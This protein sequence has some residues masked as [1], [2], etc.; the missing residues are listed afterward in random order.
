MS[1]LQ[2]APRMEVSADFDQVA[3]VTYILVEQD[4]YSRYLIVNVLSSL[5]ACSV[6]PCFDIIFSEFGAPAQLKTDSGP[7]FNSSEFAQTVF[8]GRDIRTK[9]S[10]L[11][12]L[13]KIDSDLHA[14]DT[15][16]KEIMK[17]YADQKIYMKL[18]NL[19][20]RDD[21]LVIY[22]DVSKSKLPYQQEPLTVVAK[23]G[24]MIT[25]KRGEQ[26]LSRNSSFFKKSTMPM[27]SC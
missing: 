5:T 22:T 12:Q 14:K 2:S 10:S 3:E 15:K 1:P 11:A 18:S 19:Q 25:T 20:V 7:P 6:V 9:L 17:L 21:I 23:K 24:S 26:I 8:F 16:A 27:S 4:E 13:P